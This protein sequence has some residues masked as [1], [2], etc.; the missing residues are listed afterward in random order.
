MA[1]LL[2]GLPILAGPI[3]VF[4]TLEQGVAFGVTAATAALSAIAA[5][6]AFGVVYSWTS[7]TRPWPI[8]LAAG[9]TAW[10]VSALA[11]SQLPS[12][13]GLA[14]AVAAAALFATPSLLPI[15]VPPTT[16]TARTSGDLP[17]RMAAGALMTLTVTGA[18]ATVGDTWSGLM[19]VFPVL[20][21]ILAVYT[22]RADGA[23]G[24][25][26]LYRGM[27]RGLWSFAVY[28]AVLVVLMPQTTLTIA[29]VLAIAS[30][31]GT[32]GLVQ[33][34]IRSRA[35]NHSGS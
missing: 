3:L 17:W 33:L 13:V 29:T 26:S 8:A 12:T 14:L 18:A 30:A 5:L 2:S 35:R 27:V 19:A 25:V 6:L 32:Q 10:A 7:L 22:H 16:P 31:V 24:V 11:L 1:G 21:V 20:S 4:V 23:H 15:S 34:G 9:L 28:F